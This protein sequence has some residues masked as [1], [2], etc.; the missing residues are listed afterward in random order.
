MS[1]ARPLTAMRSPIG[2]A[3]AGVVGVTCVALI[4]RGIGTHSLAR[5]L[6]GAAALFPAVL[7]LE[8]AQVACTTLAMRSL[9]GPEVPRAQLLRAGIIGY[10]VM[11]LFPA[12]RAV[13][14]VARASL[15]TRWVGAARATAAA[16]RIQV[17]AL[18]A[19][20]LISAIAAAAVALKAPAPAWLPIAIAGNAAAALAIGASLSLA[21]R[22][23][24][25]AWLGRVVPKARGFGANLDGVLEAERGLPAT[26]MAWEFAGR[27]CQVAQNAVLLAC[28]GGAPGLG[29]AL[30]SE[31][32]HLVGAAV[33]DLI[34]GQLGVTEGHYTL[35]A[36]ALGL[37]V[38]G[39]VAIALL[40]HF[41]QLTFVLAGSLV[42][43]AWPV[44]A[45]PVPGRGEAA[46]SAPVQG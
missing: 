27:L 26:A 4:V 12:G 8:G 35:A 36:S 24:P 37:P 29:S 7:A 9:Y 25:G 3:A 31:G 18:F 44:P 14:E 20:A 30:T 46:S 13:A 41:S 22:R 1:F 11:G 23:R 17:A 6:V 16:A 2:R 32:I 15:L 5:V 28:V 45:P 34:P 19:N 33:G 38:A 42:S 10:A 40:A 21:A 43:A 39:A